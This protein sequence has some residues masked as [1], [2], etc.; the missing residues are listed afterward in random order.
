M[1]YTQENFWTKVIQGGLTNVLQ[2][3]GDIRTHDG[4]ETV[5]QGI[6]N[7]G[8]VL[9]VINTIPSYEDLGAVAN[10]FSKTKQVEPLQL[11]LLRQD[12]TKNN[13]LLRFRQTLLS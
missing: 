9:K 10:V 2:Y 3:R 12:F 1:D 13:Y 5:R 11:F 8:D 4:T 7:P 6:G